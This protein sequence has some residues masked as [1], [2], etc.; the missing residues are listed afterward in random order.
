MQLTKIKVK[1]DVSCELLQE[2]QQSGNPMDRY[3]Q[4]ARS[5]RE[6]LPAEPDLRDFV[7]F[8]TLAANSH[9]TQP[10]KFRTA[11]NTVDILPDFARRT[12]VVDP[13]DHHLYVTLGCAAENLVI[14]ANASGRPA[15]VTVHSDAAGDF[16]IRITLGHGDR[17]DGSLCGAIPMR[18]STKSIY[19]GTRLSTTELQ[20]L[21]ECAAREGVDA[22]LITECPKL[23]QALRLIQAGNSVQMDDPNF[24]GEL[25]SWIRFS[26]KTSIE[27]ADGL[28]GPSAGNP[29]SPDWLG[30][31][32]FDF[33]FRKKTENRKLAEQLA[34]SAGLAV[35]V[36]KDETPEGWIKVGRSFERFALTATAMGLRHAHVNMPIE[37]QSLRPEFAKWLGMAERR[38]DLVVRFGRAAPMPMSL[39]RSA[40][41]VIIAS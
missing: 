35:F 29:S 28:S 16:F 33:M 21:E 2:P 30:P 3:A 22:L 10:W 34:S 37:V 38:P 17:T 26:A 23:D 31:I 9:N 39:R 24:V 36:A 40:D 14:A 15:K 11:E 27:Q 5:V 6:S 4:A 13:D 1:P 18:Q 12:P 20:Q 41:E 32:L 8:A 19:D 25:K 7:R